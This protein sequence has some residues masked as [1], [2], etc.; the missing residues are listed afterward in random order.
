MAIGGFN[1]S[2]PA[3][4]LAQFQHYVRD[5]KVHYFIVGG[6]GGGSR[7]AG[8]FGGPGG[9]TSS[10]ISTWVTRHYNSRTIDGVTIYDLTQPRSSSGSASGAV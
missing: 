10:E 9:N 5:G 7:G 3:P 2:D 4:T 8:G 1:G 6:G